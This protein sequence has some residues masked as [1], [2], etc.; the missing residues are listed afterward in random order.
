[1]SGRFCSLARSGFF[2]R[3]PHPIK[4]IAQCAYTQF[5]IIA[6]TEALLEFGQGQIILLRRLPPAWTALMIRWRSA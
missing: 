6:I 3:E 4:M 5:Y 1:M 2:I